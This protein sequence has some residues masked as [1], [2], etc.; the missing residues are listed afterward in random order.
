MCTHK[1]FETN[2][3]FKALDNPA[4][5]INLVGLEILPEQGLLDIMLNPA[6]PREPRKKP[7]IE[8]M[9]QDEQIKKDHNVRYEYLK[10]EDDER[11]IGFYGNYF[12]DSMLGGLRNYW[13]TKLGI[14]TS[15]YK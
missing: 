4:G 5:K 7:T 11:L 12:A 3:K 15:K 10:I 2:E 14:I 13:I 9:I 8:E 6:I 1:I